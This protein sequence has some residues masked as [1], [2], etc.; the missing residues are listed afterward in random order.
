MS[1]PFIRRLIWLVACALPLGC[2]AGEAETADVGAGGNAGAIGAGGAGGAGGAP[3][4]TGGGGAA[5]GGPETKVLALAFDLDPDVHAEIFDLEKTSDTLDAILVLRGFGRTAKYRLSALRIPA[6]PANDPNGSTQLGD[7]PAPEWR[8]ELARLDGTPTKSV[9]SLAETEVRSVYVLGRSE[10]RD[11]KFSSVDMANLI[12]LA[13]EVELSREGPSVHDRRW[14]GHPLVEV[15]ITS[16]ERLATAELTPLSPQALRLA[17]DA[18]AYQLQ[19]MNVEQPFEP[20]EDLRREILGLDEA[21]MPLAGE[22]PT[23]APNVQCTYPTHATA[24]AGI[25]PAAPSGNVTAHVKYNT[26]QVDALKVDNVGG[27]A[28]TNAA[29]LT[30]TAGN[31]SSCPWFKAASRVDGNVDAS[32]AVTCSG[33]TC[34]PD[35]HEDS[36]EAMTL[37]VSY[38]GSEVLNASGDGATGDGIGADSTLTGSFFVCA[39][40][41]GPTTGQSLSVRARVT[42]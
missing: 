26:L 40:I 16:L 31:A 42:Q 30:L 39:G 35:F 19:L 3:Q 10:T 11:A 6:T 25:H 27:L 29:S 12:A 2:G 1:T 5:V 23:R 22:A 36:A 17:F 28:P 21:G 41:A 4:G 20:A 8:V 34:C 32:A 7:P 37:S 38:N 33:T 13:K 9:L 18:F 24:N 14:K 15:A